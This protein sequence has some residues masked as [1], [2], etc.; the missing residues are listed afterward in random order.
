MSAAYYEVF[1]FVSYKEGAKTGLGTS[2]DLIANSPNAARKAAMV[3][4]RF[5]YPEAYAIE[6]Q[7]VDRIG[8]V[9]KDELP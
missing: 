4:A 5:K 6:V 8:V 7:K 2:V 9:P 3:K 1:L